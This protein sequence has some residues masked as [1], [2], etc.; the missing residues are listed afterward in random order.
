MTWL[1]SKYLHSSL[2]LILIDVFNDMSSTIWTKVKCNWKTN[3][4]HTS[5][6]SVLV[7]SVAL[8]CSKRS[9]ENLPLAWKYTET[10][11]NSTHGVS[12]RGVYVET[13]QSHHKLCTCALKK[14]APISHFIWKYLKMIYIDIYYLFII[15]QFEFVFENFHFEVELQFSMSK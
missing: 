9:K 14:T 15:F 12:Q 1:T 10:E 8:H 5:V 2:K 7:R 11:E 6:R 3:T 4:N 13:M